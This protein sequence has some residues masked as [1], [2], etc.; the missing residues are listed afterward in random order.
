M[1]AFALLEFL[2]FMAILSVIIV[3]ILGN[4]RQNFSKNSQNTQDFSYEFVTFC[5]KVTPNCILDSNIPTLTPLFEVN[6]TK[7][8]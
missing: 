4:F 8:H 3:G 1:K 6:A 5:N 2:V 7:V